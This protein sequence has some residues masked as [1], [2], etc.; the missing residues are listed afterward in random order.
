LITWRP[1]ES[2]NVAQVGWPSGDF[3]TTAGFIRYRNGHAYAYLGLSRQRIVYMATRCKSVGTYVNEV[4]K[5]QFPSLRVPDL[6]IN[7]PPF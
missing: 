1:V 4:V 3:D 6:D 5:T 7:R 2:S